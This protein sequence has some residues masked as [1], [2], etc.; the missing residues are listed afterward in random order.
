MGALVAVPAL[1]QET[2]VRQQQKQN[3]VDRASSRLT[4]LM[5]SSLLNSN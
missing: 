3:G 1:P 2:E 4:L 5:H